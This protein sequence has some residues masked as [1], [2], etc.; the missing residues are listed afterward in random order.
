MFLVAIFGFPMLSDSDTSKIIL[1]T[2]EISR[3]SFESKVL[4]GQNKEERGR[5]ELEMASY[6]IQVN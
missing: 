6:W 2:R 3:L 1:L 5:I 4:I